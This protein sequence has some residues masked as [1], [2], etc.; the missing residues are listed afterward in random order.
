MQRVT[1]L[2]ILGRLSIDII[3][4][5]GYKVSALEIEEQLREHPAIADCAVVGVE[6]PEWG[7]RVCVAVEV[8]DAQT[9]GLDELRG[10]ARE[11]LAPYK[12]P[13][14]LHIVGA[15]PRNA[16]GKVIKSEVVS[17]VVEAG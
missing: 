16:V 13:R 17:M 2:R 11:R 6:D 1:P 3:L 5:G 4:T 8:A 7:E 12:I 10:W 9:I 14:T 15:L